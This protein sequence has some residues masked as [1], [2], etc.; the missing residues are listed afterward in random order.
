M[1]IEATPEGTSAGA[2][3]PETYVPWCDN[4]GTDEYLII[5]SVEPA[6]TEDSAEFLEISYTCSECDR[7]YG[8]P[9]RHSPLWARRLAEAPAA[10]EM[11]YMHCGEPMKPKDARTLSIFAPLSTEEFAAAPAA[12]SPSEA[13]ALDNVRMEVTVLRC[14]CGFQIELPA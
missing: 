1:S 2:P 13:A 11:V 5:E 4:C 8:H 6:T 14:G 9:I 7:F 12:A 10:E 3:A